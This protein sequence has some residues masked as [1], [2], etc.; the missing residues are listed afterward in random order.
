VPAGSSGFVNVAASV[1]CVASADDI[2]VS[3]NHLNLNIAQQL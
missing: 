1:D 2:A 3:A